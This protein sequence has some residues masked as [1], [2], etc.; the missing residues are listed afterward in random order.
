MNDIKFTEAV[1][2]VLL[3]YKSPG[4]CPD[5]FVGEVIVGA[6]SITS[7]SSNNENTDFAERKNIDSWSRRGSQAVFLILESPH[8]DE[9]VGEIGP[10]KGVTGENIR[11]LFGEACSLS[12]YLQENT[13]PLVLVNAVQYQCSLGHPTKY[14]RDRIFAEVWKHGGKND[15]QERIE[16]MYSEG[17]LIINA[18]TTGSEKIKNWE[19]VK[20]ALEEISLTYVKVEHPSNWA[21]R[22][23]IAI[24]SGLSPSYGW[25]AKN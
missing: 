3:K 18:C 23:N 16:S 1:K 7:P 8:I 15:F 5:Q 14:F 11:R 12:Q 21:R 2:T 19:L 4:C 24:K 13:Y 6:G 10:A 25:N 17:D 22:K 9:Y 20:F